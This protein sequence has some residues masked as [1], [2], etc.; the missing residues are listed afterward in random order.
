[1]KDIQLAREEAI[2]WTRNQDIILQYCN[3]TY[4]DRTLKNITTLLKNYCSTIAIL[5]L[6]YLLQLLSLLILHTFYIR[7]VWS[8]S[9]AIRNIYI[10]EYPNNI[11]KQ[12][13]LIVNNE[14]F[15][16]SR[17]FLITLN[18]SRGYPNRQVV[19]SEHRNRAFVSLIKF[20]R[21]CKYYTA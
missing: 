12:T 5:I 18:N 20:L 6:I 3:M 13:E 8:C 7:N 1:M 17:R 9:K 16:L 21:N 10:Y 11:L 4:S 15:R 19:G 14:T 2:K